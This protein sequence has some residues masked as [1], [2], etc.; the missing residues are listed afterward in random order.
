[1]VSATFDGALIDISGARWP[2]GDR[3][4]VTLAL[5]VDGVN[6]V[7]IGQRTVA[8]NGRWALVDIPQPFENPSFVYVIVVGR[9]GQKTVTPV[10]IK[11]PT[12]AP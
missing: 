8:A 11:E 4:T 1:V 10:L 7:V 6:G 2:A 9:S 12:P 3:I 5:S